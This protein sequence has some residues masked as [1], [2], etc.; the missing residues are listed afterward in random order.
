MKFQIELEREEDGRWIAEVPALAGVLAYG[1][2]RDEAISRVQALALRVLAERLEHGEAA[3]E[4]IMV[5]FQAA[6]PLGRIRTM[7]RRTMLKSIPRIAMIALM[8][9]HAPHAQELLPDVAKGLTV[10][11]DKGYALEKIGDG[12]YFVTDGFYTTM[13]MTT[14]KGVIVVDAP[15]TLGEKMLQAVR[16]A[17]N[18]PIKWVIYSHSHAD[19][20]GA[21][22]I[23]PKDAVFKHLY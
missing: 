3:P 18:E 14:G 11:Q 9:G 22:G 23:Y 13:F 21:A 17:T 1:Q 10:P 2:S 4:L 6:C 15:P 20:V 8:L 7:R 19:H 16:E 12:L 5:S